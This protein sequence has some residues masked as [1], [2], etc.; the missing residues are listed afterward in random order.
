[1]DTKYRITQDDQEWNIQSVQQEK[2][3]GV[4]T[5]SDMA[6]SHINVWKQRPE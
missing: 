1:M 2:D 5:F 3:L 6:V 4:L